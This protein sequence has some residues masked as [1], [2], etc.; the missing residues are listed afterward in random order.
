M[1]APQP[2]LQSPVSLSVRTGEVL[3]PS[4]FCARW[5]SETQLGEAPF[6]VDVQVSDVSSW[7]SR[8]LPHDSGLT[9][10]GD[11]G[12]LLVA[13][14]Q[15]D[16]PWASR[17]L[18]FYGASFLPP[19]LQPCAAHVNGRHHAFSDHVNRSLL[20]APDGTRAWV[21]APSVYEAQRVLLA[22]LKGVL[23]QG[24]SP[25]AVLIL[26]PD[27]MTTRDW[28]NRLTLE[29]VPVWGWPSMEDWQCCL[30]LEQWLMICHR[31]QEQG[32]TTLEEVLNDPGVLSTGR[33]INTMMGPLGLSEPLA[34]LAFQGVLSGQGPGEVLKISLENGLGRSWSAAMKGCLWALWAEVSQP[35]T[36]GTDGVSG[37]A[38]AAHRLQAMQQAWLFQPNKPG[39]RVVTLAEGLGI[40]SP[41]LFLPQLENTLMALDADTHVSD[42][43]SPQVSLWQQI[44][45]CGSVVAGLSDAGLSWEMASALQAH[46]ASWERLPVLPPEDAMAPFVMTYDADSP[47]LQD[48]GEWQAK[49]PALVLG[50]KEE[51]A[52]SPSSVETFLRCPRQFF[53]QHLLALRDPAQSPQA[54]L[55]T[56][57]H[58]LM[59]CLNQQPETERTFAWLMTLVDQLFSDPPDAHALRLA[60][61]MPPDWEEISELT[62]LER[63]QLHQYLRAAFQDLEAQGYFRHTAPVVAVEKPLSFV[64]PDLLPG[65][66]LRGRADVI[67]HKPMG[68]LE[69]L[70]YKTTRAKYASSKYET[71]MQ[72]LWH[73][74][75]PVDWEAPER[76]RQFGGREY[77]L[78]LYWLMAQAT[79]EYEGQAVDVSIQLVRAPK[80]GKPASGCGT[81]TLTHGELQAGKAHLLD[82]LRRGVLEPLKVA[83]HFE[84]LGDPASH[85]A[86]CAYT[87][88][89]EGPQG[90]QEEDEDGGFGD[91]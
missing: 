21:E 63:Y 14:C 51:I 79:P 32:W 28:G 35:H 58:R 82:M 27:A 50:P 2:P 18:A 24:V 68:G 43:F 61:L 73:A 3:C 16:G 23:S 19:A 30:A 10:L 78:P 13:R 66:M 4:F 38:H 71:N 39:V 56:L 91:E 47:W 9:S 54:A 41:Y 11:Q 70:D 52:L 83:S 88:L 84:P 77:Q 65:L 44:A 59:E 69:I 53:Y 29:G 57:V 72:P 7:I 15:P 31:I 40:V 34:M 60:G 87:H 74:L 48:D 62:A 46:L 81:Y 8:T 1:H 26:C 6:G 76:E 45:V 55:G 80:P 64:Q 36:A 75:D 33:A 42:P 17:M 67:R 12:R 37:F 90:Q 86:Y 89:C 85:C 25:E 49:D 20:Q 5:F 22:Q